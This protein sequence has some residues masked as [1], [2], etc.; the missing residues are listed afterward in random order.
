MIVSAVVIL[1][2]VAIGVTVANCDYEV[3]IDICLT[4]NSL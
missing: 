1:P 3:I 4:L 2:M